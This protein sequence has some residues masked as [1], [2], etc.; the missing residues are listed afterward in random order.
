MEER[1]GAG[2]PERPAASIGIGGGR[3]KGEGLHHSG[4]CGQ[5]TAVWGNWESF[6]QDFHHP[7]PLSP[8]GFLETGSPETGQRG[9]KML[10][11]VLSLP[12]TA[13]IPKLEIII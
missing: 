6:R 13:S 5:A 9:V 4:Y 7:L 1:A 8:G 10:K 11:K 2:P 12:P 3:R